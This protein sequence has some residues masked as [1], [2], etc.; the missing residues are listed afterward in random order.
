MTSAFNYFSCIKPLLD[1]LNWQGEPRKLFEAMP[2][3]VSSLNLIDLR[4]M[5]ANL[6]YDSRQV[7]TNLRDIKKESTPCLFINKKNIYLIHDKNDHSFFVTNCGTEITE[8]LP[9]RHSSRGIALFFY[10]HQETVLPQRKTWFWSILDRFRPFFHQLMILGLINSSLGL[11]MPLF[12]RSVYDYVVPTRSDI[13]LFYLLFGLGLT[14]IAIHFMHVTKGKIIS[15][16][17]ARIDM[18]I[19]SEV[20]RRILY[21]PMGLME[22]VTVASQI[23]R[24][25]QFDMVR[26]IFTGTLAQIVLEA[27]FTLVFLIVL[28]LIGGPL[29]LVPIF[30]ILIYA[31]IAFMIFPHLRQTVNKLS[32]QTQN[33]RSFLIE[34]LSNFSTI[35][36]LAA[37]KIWVHRFQDI[38]TA[39]SVAQKEADTLT[40]FIT[41]ISQLIMRLAAVATILW[42]VVRVMEDL[43]TIGSLMAVI[44]L[45]WR[46]L[47]PIQAAFMTISRHDQIVDSLR[48]VNRLMQLPTEKE[49]QSAHK[50]QFNGLVRFHNISF[51]YPNDT[52]L[53]LQ[54][55]TLE[56]RPGET[57][58][59]IGENGS[60]KST[61][62]K[63]LLG[64]HTPQVGFISIDGTDIR[65]FNP[66]HL[67]QSIA[68]APQQTELFHGTI[69]QNIR[70]A[71]PDITEENLREAAAMAGILDDILRLPDGFNTRLSEKTLATFSSGF[72]Q[73]INLMRAYSRRSKILVL[74]EPSSNLDRE[75]DEILMTTL[76]KLKREKTIILI[77][78]R[79]A[80]VNLADRVLA[81]QNGY[82]RVF[83]PREKVLEVLSGGKAA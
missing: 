29:V 66:I 31:L 59:I 62:L 13:T 14:L 46:A 70:L 2:H 35:R 16:M 65:Q 79:P 53:S 72:L 77:T 12:I 81:L 7:R 4:N 32:Q 57:V 15:Y 45:V 39:V 23:A 30:M 19:G 3:L 55:V 52:S 43:M 27:P 75:S 5:M 20:L 58:A 21:L 34:A 78:H 51:R 37:E 8:T 61:M 25:K 83:G 68:Y 48:Q 41:N 28:G 60:G 71:A 74:D 76:K 50:H 42:G 56:A 18:I 44:L 82:M 54:G 67:R 26:E 49:Y 6:G 11:L 10:K 24:L 9:T 80:L 73:K 38:G 36:G 17:G 63:L 1:A 22:G 40:T 47:S 69:A 33:R 64:F